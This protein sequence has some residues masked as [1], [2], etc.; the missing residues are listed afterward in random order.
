MAGQL[1]ND[2]VIEAFVVIVLTAMILLWSFWIVEKRAKMQD[3]VQ[4]C[5]QT[6]YLECIKNG[7]MGRCEK[8]AND[9]CGID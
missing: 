6:V 8:S 4:L 2:K 1:V 3:S 7:D 5:I 9:L